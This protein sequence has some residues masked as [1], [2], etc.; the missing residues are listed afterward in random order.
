MDSDLIK[1]TVFCIVLALILIG[2][3]YIIRQT[4]L[5]NGI[6]SLTIIRK[7]Y[8]SITKIVVFLSIFL[9]LIVLSLECALIIFSSHI[10]SST[11]IILKICFSVLNTICFHGI[12]YLMFLRFWLM[13][14]DVQYTISTLDK[15]WVIHLDPNISKKD[16]Y[17]NNI[18][19]YGNYKW[20]IPRLSILYFISISIS[21][22]INVLILHKNNIIPYYFYIINIILNL[23]PILINMYIYTKTP[24]FYDHYYMRDE[25]KAINN[26]FVA[27][28]ILQF[29][30]YVS[31]SIIY[32]IYDNKNKD[33]ID[34]ENKIEIVYIAL[35]IILI[36]TLCFICTGWVV[37]T[38]SNEYGSYTE[39]QNCPL[40]DDQSQHPARFR[41]LYQNQHSFP[42]SSRNKTDNNAQQGL[43]II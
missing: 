38:I 19:K 28:L 7:R 17:F 5:L 18:E 34:L 35:E 21:I 8:S 31:M 16:W 30:H 36:G 4:K 40:Q 33:T 37:A 29:V 22:T 24:T 41:F 13:Y 42:A 23:I 6:S 20:L 14:F 25:M 11:Y 15:E 10:S 26:V 1:L 2:T 43:F 39:A 32:G 3:I 9:I 27:Y 12:L